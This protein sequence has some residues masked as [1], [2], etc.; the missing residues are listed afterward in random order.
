MFTKIFDPMICDGSVRVVDGISWVEVDG[1]RIEVSRGRVLL[2]FKEFISLSL[3]F[4]SLLDDIGRRWR[5]FVG[6]MV[7]I[8]NTK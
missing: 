8:K 3:E 2:V 4:F 6:G 1:L 7:L 5:C